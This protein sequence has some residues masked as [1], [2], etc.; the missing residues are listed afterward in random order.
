MLRL[1]L[2]ADTAQWHAVFAQA[3]LEDVYRLRTAEMSGDTRMWHVSRL[4]GACA[5][6]L[7]NACEAKFGA[8]RLAPDQDLMWFVT[9][10]RHLSAHGG[11]GGASVNVREF[12]INW[13]NQ[14]RSGWAEAPSHVTIDFD[15]LGD[16][17]KDAREKADR[18]FRVHG[19]RMYPALYDATR[20]VAEWTGV[21]LDEDFEAIGGADH[22]EVMLRMPLRSVSEKDRIVRA[23]KGWGEFTL[24]LEELVR[25][26]WS[27]SD[28]W[29]EAPPDDS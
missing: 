6:N 5:T 22:G 1:H 17:P 18:F 12:N 9:A 24:P 2:E 16:L 19:D 29:I 26:S 4:L 14:K 7:R 10:A 8:L 11:N 27:I 20:Q 3:F 21:P 25:K 15:Q 23:T 28:H 13:S